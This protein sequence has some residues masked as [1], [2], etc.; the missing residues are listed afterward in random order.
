MEDMLPEKRWSTSIERLVR[1]AGEASEAVGRLNAIPREGLA[2]SRR[3]PESCCTAVVGQ[4]GADP[5]QLGWL[6]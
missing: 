1:L 6:V 2:S 3:V 4:A 5:A